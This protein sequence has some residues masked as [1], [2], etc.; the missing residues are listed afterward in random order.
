M[1][2]LDFC[3]YLVSVMLMSTGLYIT[4]FDRNV[5]KK[6]FGLSIFQTSA[7][8]LYVSSG[9]VKG[10]MLPILVDGITKYHNPLPQ[11]LM[12]TAIVVGIST[13]AVGLSIVVKLNRAY[14]SL[15]ERYILTKTD[16]REF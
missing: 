16:E 7:L 3:H 14:G 8:I 9:Y 5:L 13:T 2:F 11:V 1:L 6:L 4:V 12:L 15:D 10:A